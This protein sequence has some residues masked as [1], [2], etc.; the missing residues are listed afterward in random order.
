MSKKRSSTSTSDP[1]TAFAQAVVDGRLVY[2]PGVR[3]ACK[4]HLL[5]LKH[6]PARGLVWDV[7]AVAH[8]IGYFRDVL[9]L[10]GGQFEG[11]PFEPNGWQAFVLGSLFGWKGSDGYRRFRT[12]IAE[13]GKGSGKSP[14]AAGIGMYGMT[15]DGEPRAEIYAAA[16]KKDQAMI[17]FRDAVAMVDQS[18][19]LAA[20]IIKSGTGEKVWN[21]AHPKSGSFFRPISSDDGQS[22]P[23]PHIGLLDEIH[24]H[25]TRTVVDMM[26]AGFK[27]RRQGLLFGITNSGTDKQSVCWEY[28]EYGL[29]VCEAGAAGVVTEGEPYFDDQFF[30]FV[31]DLDKGDDPMTDELCWQKVNPSLQFGPAD[32]ANGGVPG[33]RYLREQV[34]EARGMPGKAAT[35]KRLCFCMWG[36]P[37][38]PWISREVWEA[39]RDPIDE[40]LLRG[41]KCYAGLDL[42]STQDLTALVLV[43]EP[44]EADPFWRVLPYFWL[45]ADGLAE[46]AEQD[47]VPYIL[48]RDN[49]WL[50]ATPGR[51]VNK[52]FVIRRLVEVASRFDLQSVAYDRWRIADLKQLI[53]NEGVT[54]PPLVPFGQGYK[55]MSPALD[56]FE[57]RLLNDVMRHNGN[58]VMTWCAANAV[59]T[60][61]PA[62]NRK[63]DKSKATGRIDGIV[64]GIMGVGVTIR[65]D[66]AEGP[67]VYENRGLRSL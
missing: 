4:R 5:D 50:E 25:R 36:E 29:K 7:E 48:W 32:D 15:S 37:T 2:G 49:G 30:A 34:R 61:D 47:R 60:S 20:R 18:P 63:V 54:L 66:E 44:T 38:T 26:R 10:N 65:E 8:V 52:L 51:A 23:R 35:V 53:E 11:Q 31:C 21:L 59:T 67:S 40:E 16:T 55:D 13:T 64:A 28:H 42:S 46:K 57:T 33:Y 39:S 9:R 14:L 43:F 27:S 62:G 3:N 41:R 45:P 17:L 56:E 24:E 19:L 58:P 6:G 12:G 1:A 22:G